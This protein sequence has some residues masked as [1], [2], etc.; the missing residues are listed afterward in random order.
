MDKFDLFHHMNNEYPCSGIA[1]CDPAS[2]PQMWDIYE[3]KSDGWLFMEPR[4]VD[5]H[6]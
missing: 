5:S 1:D 2:H 3:R 4:F 6:K